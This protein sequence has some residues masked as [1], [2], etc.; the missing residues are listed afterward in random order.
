MLQK[1]TQPI[2][3]SDLSLPE[4]LIMAVEHEGYTTPTPVQA[5]TIPHMLEGHDIITQA[6]TGTGK[7]AAFALPLLSRLGSNDRLP[8]ILV[9]TPTRELAIQVADSFKRYARHIAGFRVV[10]IYGGQSYDIQFAQLKRGVHVVVG[11]PGRVMDHMRRGTLNLSEIT[12]VVL[13]EADEML[14]MG[15]IDDVDWIMER[16]PEN[17][18]IALFS[19]TMPPAIRRVAAKHLREPKEITFKAKPT[20]A[21]TILQR[22]VV[23]NG[24]D[25]FEA[26]KR[27]LEF[28][29]TEGVIVFVKTKVATVE[30]ADRLLA[31]GFRA[32][33]LNGDLA[34]RQREYTIGNLKSSKLDIIVATDVAARGLDVERI[35]HVFNYDSPHD[36]EA[37]VHRIGRTGRAGR[38]GNAVT[39]LTPREKRVLSEIK[40]TTQ[41]KIEKLNLPSAKELYQKRAEQFA[42]KIRE[43]SQDPDLSSYRSF[44]EKLLENNPEIDAIDLA[45]SLVKMVDSDRRLFLENLTEPPTHLDTDRAFQREPQPR[46]QPPKKAHRPEPD[47]ERETFYIQVGSVHGVQPSNIVGAIANEAELDS[48]YIGKIEIFE[49]YS[50]VDLPLG[51]PKQVFKL[52]KKA[53]V[54]NRQLN[55]SR[56]PYSKRDLSL[57]ASQPNRRSRALKS[58]KSVPKKKS[59]FSKPAA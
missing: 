28:E 32:S 45:A 29:D 31:C 38:L 13:D 9:L 5:S 18:Q 26:L 4:P 34:Q 10:P 25:K 40:R 27:I 57:L 6:Q 11:T 56:T 50:T 14:H 47:V 42:A 12:A 33:A 55:L 22:Y 23:T 41:Q 1:Q 7:T 59:R 43:T 19:A 49:T 8:Q 21:D 30:V 53:W 16:V 17:R 24:R 37:Y 36:T 15:F 2:A 52:L 20:A 46:P 3:F 35:S 58:K 54:C 51:M 39:F 48:E 44:A